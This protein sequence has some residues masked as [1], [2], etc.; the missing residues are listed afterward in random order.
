MS[1]INKEL[2]DV[3]KARYGKDVRQAIHDAIKE[4]D[5]VA[6]TAQDSATKMAT[7]AGNHE[8]VAR[9]CMESARESAESARNSAEQASE[10]VQLCNEHMSSTSNPHKVTKSQVGLSNVP[11]VSTN[12]QAPTYS[13]ASTLSNLTSGEKISVAFGKIAKA[14]TD[15]ISHLGSKSNPHEV[16]KS[17]IG[18]GNVENKSS[19]TIRSEITK[20]NVTNALGYTPM[21][22]SIKGSSNGVAE[23]DENGK[24]LSS[25]LPSYVDDV[26]EGTLST[27]PSTGESGKIYLDT[28]SNKTY[29][30]SGSAYAEISASI[31]LG[32]TSSTAYRGDRGKIAYEH[33]QKTS[34]NPHG[35]TKS[36]VGL[37]NV[38]NVTTNNQTP[39]FSVASTL[40]IL[41]SGEKLTTSLGKIAKAV[42]DLISHLGN[43]DN[44]HEVTKTQVGLG[45]VPNV[46]TNDQTPTFTQASTLATLTSGE[47]L[48]ISM[49]KIKKAITS[50]INHLADSVVHVTSADK[51]KWNGYEEKINNMSGG[52]GASWKLHADGNFIALELPYGWNELY[53]AFDDE[54]P[55]FG[56]FKSV[57]LIRAMFDKHINYVYVG[58]KGDIYVEAIIDTNE[59]TISFGDVYVS[60][61]SVAEDYLRTLIFYK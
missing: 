61:A 19:S 59:N 36:D 45:N 5:S 32:E 21:N 33:S 39:T 11:N 7:I 37:G 38:P 58:N 44:P 25:Q 47:K 27:F 48:S 52:G 6:D 57:Y 22:Q 3:L 29:R 43:K 8:T 50:L 54:D 31:A 34:G 42:A 16:T 1:N 49:G 12:D 53:I 56:L 51:T 35:V 28:S 26:I 2:E 9:Q 60:N 20:T 24:V 41:T 18:L 23:L 13:V 40:T 15:L 46:A 55:S 17:Q 30:W 10:S 14:I 4:V